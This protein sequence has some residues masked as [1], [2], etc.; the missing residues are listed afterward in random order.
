MDTP[1]IKTLQQILAAMQA[2]NDAEDPNNSSQLQQALDDTS[3]IL[4][5]MKNNI[6][7]G[8]EQGLVDSLNKDN[9]SMQSLTATIG[10]M[11]ADLN[12]LTATLT[13]LSNTIGTLVSIITSA[14]SAG[15]I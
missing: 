11:T 8:A 14:A 12:S 7:L 2:V 15:L 6:I 1:K 3:N 4:Q 5:E 13:S 9:A 10:Q